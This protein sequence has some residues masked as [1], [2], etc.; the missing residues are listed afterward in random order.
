MIWS[1][2]R[3]VSLE[4]AENDKHMV[5]VDLDEGSFTNSADDREHDYNM[6]VG[7]D[8]GIL[9][10][11]PAIGEEG[12]MLLWEG[13]K[14]KFFASRDITAGEEIRADYSDFV[15]SDGWKFLGL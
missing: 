10:G 1:Y 3:W 9:Y 5:C 13:C 11:D 6:A 15:E 8:D 7:N 14:L 12:R 4:T 2:V